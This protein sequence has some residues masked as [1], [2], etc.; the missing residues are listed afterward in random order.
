M[1]N[2]ENEN[3]DM[4]PLVTIVTVCRNSANTIRQTIDSVLRQNYC[5]IE[6]IIVDGKSTDATIDILEEYKRMRP[7]KFKFISEIDSGLYFAMNKGIDLATGELIGIINSDD[8]YCENA[9]SNIVDLWLRDGM[10]AMVFSSTALMDD[11]FSKAKSI[12][13]PIINLSKRHIQI[14]HP[15]TFVSKVAYN[16]YGVFNVDYK[17]AS[18]R[19]L[20]TR[21]IYSGASY[22]VLNS[23]TAHFR[24]GG[25]G[26]RIG[27]KAQVENFILD[28]KYVGFAIAFK[29]FIT[30]YI[31]SRYRAVK[32][33]MKYK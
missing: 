18:D 28:K 6:Y 8:I 29:N 22:S 11:S 20:L 10:P 26:S 13:H 5:N 4:K 3:F 17:Y 19:E 25:L 7:D 33:L 24:Q 9:I 31:Y 15:S 23:V 27:V 12:A 21:F 30:A 1:K 2:S 14:P 16:K 32:K